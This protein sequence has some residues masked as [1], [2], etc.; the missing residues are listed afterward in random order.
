MA[1]ND[2]LPWFDRAGRL[3]WLKLGCFVLCLTPG[4][5]LLL[6]YKFDLLGT[7]PITV[8]LHETGLWAVRFLAATLA[9]TPFRRIFSWSRLIV[10]RRQLGL[11]VLAYT[12]IHLTLYIIDQAYDLVQVMS[13]IVHRFYLGL[14][15]IGL[16]GLLT[17]GLTSTDGAVRRLGTIRWNEIHRLIYPVLVASLIHFLLQSKLDVT[18]ACLMLGL[19]LLLLAY[20]LA[21]SQGWPLAGWTLLI[22]G[23][24]SGVLTMLLE[25]WW[26]AS[27]GRISFWRILEANLDPFSTTRPGW[28]VIIVGVGIAVIATAHRALGQN[29]QAGKTLTGK[30]RAG[31]TNAPHRA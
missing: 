27:G 26:Y 24:A 30:T 9:I 14:G 18:E 1:F 21:H 11:T 4:L 5:Y 29:R 22:I 7:K 20:R 19:F 3:S 6:A 31:K 10:L 17:L 13:E 2:V 15:F 23:V 16:A 25:A 8:L 28:W 12:L